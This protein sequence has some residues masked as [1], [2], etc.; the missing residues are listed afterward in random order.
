[1]AEFKSS[2]KITLVDGSNNVFMLEEP[3]LYLSDLIGEVEVPV[4]FQ[5][6]FAS[7][8]RVPLVYSAYGGR[9]HRSATIHDYLF[10]IDCTPKVTFSKANRVFL[11]AMKSRGVPWYIRHPMYIGVMLGAIWS[12]QKKKVTDLLYTSHK[13]TEDH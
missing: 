6:D 10:R 5:T 13:A 7:V 9:S 8:P 2:L 1:M 3:L 4:G 12:Y 11:E